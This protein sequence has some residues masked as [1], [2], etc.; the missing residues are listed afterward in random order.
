MNW[1]LS[2]VPILHASLSSFFL[3]ICNNAW[4]STTRSCFRSDWK[5]LRISFGNGSL[6]WRWSWTMVMMQPSDSPVSSLIFQ[7]KVCQLR[8]VVF[9]RAS[10]DGINLEP[11]SHL[12]KI[13]LAKI[14]LDREKGYLVHRTTAIDSI[15][16]TPSVNKNSLMLPCL[17]HISPPYP[18]LLC[19]RVS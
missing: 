13:P 14:R 2:T 8:F 9:Q 4:H 1:N 7:Q 17:N 3:S 11:I 15:G 12:V 10:L 19:K 6:R 16:C 18:Y 5:F